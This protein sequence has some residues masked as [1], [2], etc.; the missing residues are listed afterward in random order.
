MMNLEKSAAEP[1]GEAS[2]AWFY[3]VLGEREVR[4]AVPD[5]GRDL[6]YQAKED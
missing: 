4:G 1:I 6:D 3:A 2:Q 5:V